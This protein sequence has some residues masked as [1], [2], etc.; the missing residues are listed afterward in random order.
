[1]KGIG[2]AEQSMALVGHIY[3]RFDKVLSLACLWVEVLRMCEHA[4]CH[5]SKSRLK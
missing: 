3:W 4:F 2:N 5:F 1:M